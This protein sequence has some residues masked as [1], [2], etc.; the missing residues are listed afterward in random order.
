MHA[1]LEQQLH[2]AQGVLGDIP[3]QALRVL[4]LAPE[5]GYGEIGQCWHT[6]HGRILL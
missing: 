6:G 5:V 4:D 2:S 1:I 3:P